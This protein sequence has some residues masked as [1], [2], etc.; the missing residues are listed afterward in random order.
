MSSGHFR[1]PLFVLDFTDCHRS[2]SLHRS[3]KCCPYLQQGGGDVFF[4][5]FFLF[6]LS[7]LIFVIS[8]TLAGFSKTK[9]YTQKTTKGTKNIKNV[10]EKLE[11]MLFSLNLEKFT[12]D[13]K[14][15]HRHVCGVCD[16]YEVCLYVSSLCFS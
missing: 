10:S 7:Y 11:Y 2:I 16:K 12:P 3:A 5:F 6:L 13:R 14:F 1:L 4:I 9:F 15:L 8:F